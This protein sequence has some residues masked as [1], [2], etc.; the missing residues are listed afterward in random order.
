VRFRKSIRKTIVF[1]Y[2]Q[3]VVLMSGCR[4]EIDLQFTKKLVLLY[5]STAETVVLSSESYVQFNTEC[6]KDIA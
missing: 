6:W 2:Y 1:L 5:Y 3:S 4:E